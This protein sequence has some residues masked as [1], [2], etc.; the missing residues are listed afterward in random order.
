MKNVVI[1]QGAVSF[2]RVFRELRERMQSVFKSLK[3]TM[4]TV[5]H[6]FTAYKRFD[7]NKKCYPVKID[8]T[9]VKIMDQVI[10][11]KPKNLIKKTNM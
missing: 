4:N 3:Q 6:V 9:R 8:F 1:G 2:M 7:Y 11:R 10:E 5:E